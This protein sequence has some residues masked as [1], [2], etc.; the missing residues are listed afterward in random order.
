[1]ILNSIIY[2]LGSKW[3][4]KCATS[5]PVLSMRVSKCATSDLIVVILSKWVSNHVTRDPILSKRV[6]NLVIVQLKTQ[7]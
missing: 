7:Y 3:V 5:D 6:S 1:M 4:S 2:S